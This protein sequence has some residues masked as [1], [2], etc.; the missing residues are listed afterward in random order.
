METVGK[1]STKEELASAV[2]DSLMHLYYLDLP[3]DL[4]HLLSVGLM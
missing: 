4:A 2:A 3:S 1:M